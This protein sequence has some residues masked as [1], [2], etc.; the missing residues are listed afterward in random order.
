MLQHLISTDNK[1]ENTYQVCKSYEDIISTY[2]STYSPLNF[3]VWAL[4]GGGYHSNVKIFQVIGKERKLIF[5]FG[6]IEY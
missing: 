6:F 1:I 2:T 3:C 5:A 4:Y